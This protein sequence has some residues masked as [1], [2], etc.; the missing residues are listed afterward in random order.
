MRAREVTRT[1][2]MG[3]P[4]WEQTLEAEGEE[5]SGPRD[6]QRAGSCPG[7]PGDLTASDSAS[8]LGL[9]RSWV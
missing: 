3:L 9:V 8:D 6:T 7:P 5:G 4:V 2:R 1:E